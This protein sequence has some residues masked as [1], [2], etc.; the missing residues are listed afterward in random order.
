[1][2]LA[3]GPTFTNSPCSP[4]DDSSAEY[5]LRS[6]TGPRSW[7][8]CWNR[9]HKILTRSRLSNLRQVVR[10]LDVMPGYNG[11]HNSI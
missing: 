6:L 11:L 7:N 1:M 5:P 4:A 10:L 8:G 2:T 9:T 3:N